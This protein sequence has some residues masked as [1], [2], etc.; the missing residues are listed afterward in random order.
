METAAQM[1][2]LNYGSLD[3]RGKCASCLCLENTEFSPGRSPTAFITFQFAFSV[4]LMLEQQGGNFRPRWSILRLTKL[5]NKN[6]NLSTFGRW[7]EGPRRR[8]RPKHLPLNKHRGAPAEMAGLLLEWQLPATLTA[9][10]ATAA[11]AC[12]SLHNSRIDLA[13]NDKSRRRAN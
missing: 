2:L 13:E 8:L 1:L 3:G 4:R 5:R 6:P 7:M 12:A 11:A 10:A 9:A